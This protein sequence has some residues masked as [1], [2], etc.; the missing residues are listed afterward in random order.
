M[1]TILTLAS[2]LD[3]SLPPDSKLDEPAKRLTRQV[4]E[5][6]KSAGEEAWKARLVGAGV[7]AGEWKEAEA[8][9]AA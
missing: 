6:L 7:A 2:P 1:T 9:L 4:V 8:V 5:E 3:P